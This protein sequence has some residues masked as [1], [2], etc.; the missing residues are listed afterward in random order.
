[1]VVIN[2][3]KV[4]YAYLNEEGKYQGKCIAELSDTDE[5]DIYDKIFDTGYNKGY[6]EG[7]LSR[8]PDLNIIIDPLILKV[9]GVLTAVV[10]LGIALFML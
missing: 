2:D 1:M 6:K 4:Y 9:V 10:V 3:N 5:E 7:L 8:E